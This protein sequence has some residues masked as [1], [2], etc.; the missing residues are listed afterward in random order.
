MLN[1]VVQPSKTNVVVTF[2]DGTTETMGAL[3]SKGNNPGTLSS[4]NTW[5]LG[6]VD[7]TATISFVT[8]SEAADGDPIDLDNV[9]VGNVAPAFGPSVP[10]PATVLGGGALLG[11]LAT[12]RRRLGIE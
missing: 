12:A 11:L 5:F 10:L 7:P 9:Y 1:D 3:N 8:I 4:N 2:S 6:V